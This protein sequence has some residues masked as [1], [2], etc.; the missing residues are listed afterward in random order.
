MTT[1]S[2]SW[3]S[4]R[5]VLKSFTLAWV[6][7]GSL[8]AL[9]D[10]WAADSK[11]S[12][13]YEDALA[14]Y[15]KK[16]LKGAI[17]QLKNALQI[18]KNMMPVQMLLGKALLQNGEVAAAEVA[19]IEALRLGANRAEVVVPLGQAYLA[20]GKAASIFERPAL[21]LAGLPPAAQLQVLLLRSA[22]ST[23]LGDDRGTL[24]AIEDARAIDPTSPAV[25]LAE[26]PMR[27][28]SKQFAEAMVAA[29]RALAAL[30]ESVDAWYQKGS[31][32]QASG[33]LQSAL[34]AYER[35]LKL[36]GTHVDVRVARA[37]LYMDLG[38]LTDAAK[39]IDELKRAAPNDPRT[40]Y[41]QAL[42]AERDNKPELARAALKEVT[43]LIDPVPI[44]FILY[45]PQ[46]LLLNALAHFGLNEP[47][48][49]KQYFEVLHR[50]QSNT[51]A[52]KLLAQ[53]LLSEGRIDRAIDVLEVYLK[54]SPADAPALSL[55]SSALMSK[56]QHARAASLMQQALQTKDTP[57]NRTVLGLSLVGSGK[58]RDG[59]PELEAAYK[60]DPRQTQAATV[61][62]AYYLRRGQVARAES[63]AEG[64]IKQQ[65]S[66]AG[67]FNLLGMVKER[68][69]NPVAAQ[70]AFEQSVK[71]DKN[72]IPPRINLA[73]LAT[74]SKGYAAAAASLGAVLRMDEKNAEA[75]YE[76]AVLSD[77]Q[78]VPT[79][80][81][82]WLEK[83]SD[84]SG[85][86]EIRWDLAL[87]DFHLR[88]GRAGPALAAAKRAAFKVPDDLAGL[89]V[90]AKAQLANRDS[91][92]AKTSL[93]N[94]TRLA[95]YNPVLQVQIAVLQLAADN[96][97]GAAYSLEK[98]LSG[99]PD[100][101]PALAM[102]AEIELR[103]ADA[104][105]AER[106]ARSI[107]EKYPKRAVGHS[108][109]GDVAMHRGQTAAAIEAYRRAHQTE[110]STETLLRLF[111]TLTRHGDG[112]AAQQ[113]VEQW[114]K[115]YPNDARA[116]EALA[117]GYAQD[118]NFIAAR[119]AYENVLI[120]APDNGVTLNNLANVLLR[121]KDPG[122]V[123]IAEQAV[124][125]APNNVNT[126][127]TLGW[128]LVHA[129]QIDR[130]LQ[131]L[132]DARLR[133]PDNPEIRYHLAVALSKTGRKA[134]ARDELESALKGVQAFEGAS[135][136]AALLKS[137]K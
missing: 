102:M 53:I 12:R 101:L 10:A 65:P 88:N 23:D 132:R 64:L 22:A 36:D 78:G 114:V 73:R 89:L 63:I 79:D 4:S 126:I 127:D 2:D 43:A 105:K 112:K 94:A 1:I 119:A 81:Q 34:A 32:A 8:F 35:V 29:D 62:V 19:L 90:Y 24:K 134:E 21:A 25:L 67:F 118:R 17:I 7:L 59:I 28:R 56:G 123:K 14:R 104:A 45:R 37:G 124:A 68:A 122:V 27:I 54:T 75:M 83:A 48:K 108:L 66:N 128:A 84:V 69:G 117:D 86:K 113:L 96:V 77:R 125:K 13:Y 26:I 11:A 99:Q 130:G 70:R 133:E 115:K 95:E 44:D 109:L 50:V 6:V 80:T 100:F 40:A 120:I 137:L 16:D 136:A 31:I 51:P 49:A 107:V 72:F 30:P 106:R 42:S 85:A 116:L 98:A 76:M 131:Y 97:A 121:L 52:S 111:R 103:Q 38:R 74:A 71:L 9:H 47:A 93:I 41:L 5:L 82:R 15:E 135:D 129:G 91:K 92:G 61:L 87:A 20:Q 3:I 46:L 18:D 33:D 60:K 39:D 55:L 58:V 110:P 57:E